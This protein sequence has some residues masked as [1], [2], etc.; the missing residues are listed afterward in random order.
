MEA[1]GVQSIELA[2]FDTQLLNLDIS[3]TTEVRVGAL[4]VLTF[5]GDHPAAADPN[6]SQRSIDGVRRIMER[7]AEVGA[8]RVT[9]A[10]GAA[11]AGHPQRVD[12]QDA[13]NRT[14]DALTELVRPA[15]RLGI[16][17]AVRA[18][19]AGFLI[20]PVELRELIHS[21]NSSAVGVDLDA[22]GR[23]DPLDWRDWF[24]TLE[25]HVCALGVTARERSSDELHTFAQR[26]RELAANGRYTGHVVLRKMPALEP[27]EATRK[28]EDQ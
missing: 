24:R 5:S 7:A 10:P 23:A 1:A 18:S 2:G 26:V 16:K 21:V 12:Y 8:T 3:Q 25:P 14:W 20:S 27:G 11:Q 9:L 6:A 17:L 15:E 28:S 22:A 4:N 13:L 19:A